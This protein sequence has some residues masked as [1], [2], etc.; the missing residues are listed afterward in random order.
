[1]TNYERIKNMSVEEMAEFLCDNFECNICPAFDGNYCPNSNLKIC[2]KAM[3]KHLKVRSQIM[4]REKALEIITNAI[5]TDKMTVEQDK[6]LAIAQKALKKQIPKKP[7]AHIV[8][9][10]KLKIG[11]ANWCKGTTVYRCPN[12]NDFISRIYDFCYKC[13]QKIDWGNDK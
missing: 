3:K 4:T 11:N 5:Q 10:D 13:G 2:S 8:D 9:I 6:A 12:C 1:M 7:K